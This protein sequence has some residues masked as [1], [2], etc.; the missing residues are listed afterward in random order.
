MLRQSTRRVLSSALIGGWEPVAASAPQGMP[1]VPSFQ[2]PF[3]SHWT[4]LTAATLRGPSRGFASEAMHG[5]TI[6][7]VRKGGKVR[8]WLTFPS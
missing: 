2:A 7:C 4:S 8:F 1:V 5:T 3:P 6:L